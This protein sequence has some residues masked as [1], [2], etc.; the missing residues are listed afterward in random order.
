MP[1]QVDHDERRLE[2]LQVARH[3]IAERG[4]AGVS[5]REI[6]R[7]MGGS[8]TLVTHYYAQQGDLF[9]DLAS[10]SVDAWEADLDELQQKH[11]DPVELF[12]V[13]LFEWLVPIEGEDLLNERY[14]I[15]FVAAGLQGE[16][17]QDVL[18]AWEEGV[19]VVF[20][21]VLKGLVKRSEVEHYAD[22][23]RAAFNGIALSTVEHPDHWTVNR[24]RKVLAALVE[25]L[26]LPVDA[27]RGR[28]RAVRA[29]G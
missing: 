23:L 8:T 14:R 10:T 4:P 21:R 1:R 24:Q 19:K 16:S 26:G 28:T 3:L 6:G 11:P 17:T 9:K 18:D 12:N 5:F 7:R 27:S 13:V 15:N 20:R 29:T 2:I 25:G 22:V